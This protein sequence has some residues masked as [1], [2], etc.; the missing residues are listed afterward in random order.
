MFLLILDQTLLA[1]SEPLT[2]LD[3][4]DRD[5]HKVED[6]AEAGQEASVDGRM[7]HAPGARRDPAE[8]LRRQCQR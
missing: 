1:A 5:E 3:G 6:P 7:R 8:R 2:P 4:D